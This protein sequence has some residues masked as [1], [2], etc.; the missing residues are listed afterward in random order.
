MQEDG[1]VREDI[2]LDKE[3]NEARR[4]AS[5]TRAGQGPICQKEISK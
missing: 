1:G 5:L 3:E 4:K 2:S